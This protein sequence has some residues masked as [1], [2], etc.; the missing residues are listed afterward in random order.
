MGCTAV[1]VQ[2][3]EKGARHGSL[4][5]H[6]SRS[7][8]DKRVLSTSVAFI[9]AQIIGMRKGWDAQLSR[10]NSQ[11]KERDADRSEYM[12][13]GSMHGERLANTCVAFIHAQKGLWKG[14]M[15]SCQGAAKES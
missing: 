1:K 13:V 8:R 4:Q 11:K 5:V 6:A 15:R 9:Y 14:G 3:P 12:Q 2:Q 10:R 7:M